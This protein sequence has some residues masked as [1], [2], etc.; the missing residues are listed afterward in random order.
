MF[1]EHVRNIEFE[2]TNRCNAGCPLC[3]RSGR[4][5]GGLSESV[6]KSGM[7]DLDVDVHRHIIESL[8]LDKVEALDYGGCFGDPLMHPKALE[9][10]KHAEGVYQ[11]VQTNASL[12]TKKFW[13]EA[14]KI[15]NL[16]MW[17]HLDGLEDTNHIYRRLT[18]WS[19]I[20]RNAKTFLDAGGKG[21]WVFIVFR[22]NEHQVEEARAMSKEWGFDEFIV[23]KTSRRMTLGG[24]AD[25]KMLTKEGFK[26]FSYEPPENPE[27]IAEVILNGSEELPIDCY[28]EKRGTYYVNCENE[29][30]PCCE[31]AK[32][33]YLNRHQ[34]KME[35]DRVYRDINF[36]VIV[37][38]INNKFNDIIKKYNDREE[39]FRL[40]WSGRNYR[41]C[42]SRCGTSTVCQK[43]HIPQED[44]AGS[45]RF[46]GWAGPNNL[47]N[48]EW[49]S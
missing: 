5:K 24:T 36:N 44:G 8:N 28:S 33:A 18:D 26:V 6:Y 40:N 43:I 38:P 31:I 9:I 37:D 17:F 49:K 19:K 4:F 13:T 12:Q 27:Y 22:H 10:L 46:D 29:V 45:K 32:H 11:E 3:S 7:K 20:E 25:Q 47:W 35:V 30:W 41:H 15:K 21:S 1:N 23:K 14:A 42:A 39:N 48:F 16:R 34:R 2:L